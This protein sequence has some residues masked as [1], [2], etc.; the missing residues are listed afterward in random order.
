[1]AFDLRIKFSGLCL[2]VADPCEPLMHVLM[3]DWRLGGAGTEHHARIFLERGSEIVDADRPPFPVDMKDHVLDL[4]GLPSSSA[5]TTLELP[6]TVV[7]LHPTVYRKVPRKHLRRPADA[8]VGTRITVPRSRPV[9]SVPGAMWS[10]LPYGTVEMTPQVVWTIP[11]DADELKWKRASLRN[12]GADPQDLRTVRPDGR[13][14]ELRI[15]HVP[16]PD[17]CR[18]PDLGYESPHFPA[19]YRLFTG[20]R[21][22]PRLVQHKPGDIPGE[23]CLRAEGPRGGSPYTC[24]VAQAP[25]GDPS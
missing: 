2:F 6:H 17:V 16:D 20:A 4:R 24:M 10:L 7:D 13:T 21:L 14:I 1:M 8:I 18:V 3:P 22:K 25:P 15:S 23:M 19:L 5:G 12:G 11:V 9:E